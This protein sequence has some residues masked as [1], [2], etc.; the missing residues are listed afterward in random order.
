MKKIPTN[1]Q[2]FLQTLVSVC[3]P[4]PKSDITSRLLR[5]D[6]LYS[7]ASPLPTDRVCACGNLVSLNHSVSKFQRSENLSR[8]RVMLNFHSSSP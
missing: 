2:Y 5:P 1:L 6:C 8:S 4:D 3:P 7:C